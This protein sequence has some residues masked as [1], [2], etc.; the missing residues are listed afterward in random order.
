MSPLFKKNIKLILA[1]STSILLSSCAPPNELAKNYQFKP[2]TNSGV[3]LATISCNLPESSTLDENYTALI[4]L[5]PSPQ[6][7]DVER[8][9]AL[10]VTCHDIH[11]EPEPTYFSRE[12]APG[13]YIL[14]GWQANAPEDG[15]GF[16][17][18]VSP[19]A[20]TQV[21]FSIEPHKATYIGHI[22]LTAD[23]SSFRVLKLGNVGL[24]QFRKKLPQIPAND[25]QIR[26]GKVE[27]VSK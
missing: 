8:T 23:R 14:S 6:A 7:N 12:L 19:K 9:W 27:R 2:N 5:F 24:N 22:F 18:Y 26:Y 25:F 3:M 16:V 17:S 20:K 21:V 1:V 4:G 13:T 11:L 15:G 10:Q